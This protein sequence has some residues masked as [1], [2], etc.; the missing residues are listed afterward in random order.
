MKY[1][2]YTP[3]GIKELTPDVLHMD[4]FCGPAQRKRCDKEGKCL[5][6]ICHSYRLDIAKVSVF[7]IYEYGDKTSKKIDRAVKK[8]RKEEYKKCRAVDYEIKARK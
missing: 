1:V 3:I 8:Y 4:G 7:K 6:Q 2:R 5:Q